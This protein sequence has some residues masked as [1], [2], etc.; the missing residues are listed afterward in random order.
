MKKYLFLGFF[1]ILSLFLTACSD[2]NKNISSTP[3]WVPITESETSSD[4]TVQEESKEMKI[5]KI[6][7]LLP[8]SGGAAT[9]WEDAVIVY[10]MLLSEINKELSKDNVQI[11]LITEDSKC[12]GRNSVAGYNKLVWVDKVEMV[13]WAVCSS[14][15]I[16][17]AKISQTKKIPMVSALSSSPAIS[18]IGDY[19]YRF[20]NDLNATKKLNEYMESEGAKSI[21][22]IYENTDYGVGYVNAIKDIFTWEIVLDEKFSTDEKEFS[23]I[24]K[25]I[26]KNM[27]KIDFLILV[28]NSDNTTLGTL[29]ALQN[30]GILSTLV[31]EGKMIWSET[32]VTDG[33]I[34]QM[35][36]VMNGVISPML[37]DDV[38]KLG[39]QTKT[40]IE[41]FKKENQ[42]KS[43]ELFVTLDAELISLVWDIVK[44]G[45]YTSE[46]IQ[47]YLQQI[48]KESPR[49]WYFWEYYFEI[50]G[51]AIW[52][53]FLIWTVKE[54]KL[55]VIK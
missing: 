33:I 36:E 49:M 48:T 6:W 23:L 40:L 8:L 42:V 24:A 51:D 2:V 32:V 50:T 46:A 43:S 31:E 38:A 7:A 1:L 15:T 45:N 5:V 19:V 55:R 16:P 44:D 26:K 28:P 52:L 17:A 3:V 34:S 35:W 21:G 53:E 4:Q 9:Y 13:M 18:E 37:I 39:E 27:D 30:E 11:E 12:D 14:A 41:N 22:F 29:N 54:G 10:D 25:K 20:W 47:S